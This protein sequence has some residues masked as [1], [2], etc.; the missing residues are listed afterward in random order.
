M[1]NL[2]GEQLCRAIEERERPSIVLK[3]ISELRPELYEQAKMY[4]DNRI[5]EE[6][7]RITDQKHAL[8]YYL[9]GMVES[10][11][12]KGANLDGESGKTM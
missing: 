9:I 7:G 11:K 1:S 12:Q 2:S 10:D 5:V 6:R 8:L 4:I 3:A